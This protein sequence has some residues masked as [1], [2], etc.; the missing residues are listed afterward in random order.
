MSVVNLQHRAG[1]WRSSESVL[2]TILISWHLARI[3]G[4]SE[5]AAILKTARKI[6]PEIKSKI[7][8][9]SITN[10]VNCQPRMLRGV[11][12]TRDMIVVQFAK[13]IQD[14]F[15]LKAK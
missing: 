3:D 4:R 10:L 11:Y 12:M 1:G 9:D 14:N 2:L 7:T 6:R 13:E 15:N 5:S 8:Y